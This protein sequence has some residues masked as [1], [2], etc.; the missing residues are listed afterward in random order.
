MCQCARVL[1]KALHLV[2]IVWHERNNKWKS[3]QVICFPF[4][5]SISISLLVNWLAKNIMLPIISK[6]AKIW[7][8]AN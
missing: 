3:R 5:E 6:T 8:W 4:P 2:C 1:I 7:L